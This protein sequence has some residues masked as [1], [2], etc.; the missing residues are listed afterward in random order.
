MRGVWCE[1]RCDRNARAP[2]QTYGVGRVT[3][4][5][6]ACSHSADD[7]WAVALGGCGQR[8]A[9]GEGEI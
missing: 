2:G 9:A 5:A 1:E 8:Q 7:V 6:G 4:R 3:R